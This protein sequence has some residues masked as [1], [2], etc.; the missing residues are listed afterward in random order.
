MKKIA[1]ILILFLFSFSS[2]GQV[3]RFNK[4]YD[5]FG[6]ADLSVFVQETNYGYLLC[7]TAINT[8][9]NQVMGFIRIDEQGNE[10]E[11]KIYDL[12]PIVY[13]SGKGT[14]NPSDSSIY[15]IGTIKYPDLDIAAH[16]TKINQYGDT[17]WTKVITDTTYNSQ[18]LSIYRE[19]NGNLFILGSTDRTDPNVNILLVKT[20][21]IGNFIWDKEYGTSGT[22]DTGWDIEKTSDTGFVIGAGKYYFASQIGRS[23]VIKTDSL[24]NSQWQYEYGSTTYTN[25]SPDVVSLSN[26]KIMS[27]AGKGFYKDLGNNVY[28]K[29]NILWLDYSGNYIDYKEYSID[30]SAFIFFRD[31]YKIDSLNYILTGCFF[32]FPDQKIGLFKTDD[33]GDTV[34]NRTYQGITQWEFGREIKPTSDG[35]F[36]IVGTN[37]PGSGFST[38]Y[39]LI[40]VDSLGCDTLGCETVG[41]TEYENSWSENENLLAFPNPSIGKF[42]IEI[43]NVP[44]SPFFETKVEVY[45]LVGNMIFQSGNRLFQNLTEIDISNASPGIY[46]VKVYFNKNSVGSIRIIKE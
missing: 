29:P 1:H 39:R 35:G 25:Y 22:Y 15:L 24:G 28:S 20:D 23:L 9:N 43:K 12:F 40:K 32:D 30:S 5:F 37:Y 21:S 16:L 19:S 13:S 46:L 3:E 10:I 31:N 27:S 33:L 4:N 45:D 7:G 34:L 8:N 44:I 6:G 14:F 26:D 36:I 42:Y 17:I 2:S 41:I 18:G 11:K 38:D